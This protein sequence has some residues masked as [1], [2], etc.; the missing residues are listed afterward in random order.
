MPTDF[1]KTLGTPN[2]SQG[3]FDPR[4]SG[5]NY[6]SV[7][8][9]VVS[10]IDALKPPKDGEAQLGQYAAAASD[11]VLNTAGYT[12]ERERLLQALATVPANDKEALTKYYSQLS[13]LRRGDMAPLTA[14]AR[15]KKLT[16]DYIILHPGLTTKILAIQQGAFGD[17]ADVAGVS[18]Q[19]SA[20]DADLAAIEDL[21]KT[22]GTKGI[23]VDEEREFRHAQLQDE[24]SKL[25]FSAK[26]RAGQVNEASISQAY[27]TQTE[28]FYKDMLPKFNAQLK[29][30]SFKGSDILAG[31]VTA[32][33]DL[34]RNTNLM[35]QKVAIDNKM[36]LTREFQDG[37]VKNGSATLDSLIELAKATDN[38][39]A[40]A[41]LSANLR[42]LAEN[43]D[44]QTLHSK[45]GTYTIM[46]TGTDGMIKGAQYISDV[47]DKIAKGLRPS[48]NAQAKT[49]PQLAMALQF[50]D[51][52]DYQKSIAESIDTTSKGMPFAPSGNETV[53][54]VKLQANLD[55]ALAPT[56]PAKERSAALSVLAGQPHSFEAWEARGDLIEATRGSPEVLDALRRAS[57]KQLEEVATQTRVVRDE[58]GAIQ[59][60]ALN[61]NQPFTIS[62]VLDLNQY[63]KT[64][65]QPTGGI[66]GDAI[67]YSSSSAQELVARM[68][69]QYRVFSNIMP[70]AEAQKW[71]ATVLDELKGS[72]QVLPSQS[73]TFVEGSKKTTATD[74]GMIV[75]GNIDLHNRPVVKNADG[76]IST[77]RSISIGT[78][79]GEVLIPTISDDGKALS[80]QAAIALYRKT[81]R[82]LGIFATPAAADAYAEKLHNDQAKEYDTSDPTLVG[83]SADEIDWAMRPAK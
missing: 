41:E 66:Y 78:D 48:L 76:T 79:Q 1:N 63:G 70:R 60:D 75:P 31:L 8:D 38:P 22:A 15:L 24:V 17:I 42:T 51:G 54:K 81:G 25:D 61:P 30:P 45:F 12:T 6:N 11:I 9:S 33:S 53:D 56:T 26:Q 28:L 46:L 13:S 32:R 2:P 14:S 80:N 47:S 49:N 77:V 37:L 3:N 21:V 50:I 68:N 73:K 55:F 4:S 74:T 62:R 40:R 23:S 27:L 35:L 83:L 67:R 16:K 34:V 36:I 59:F 52:P 18:P 39:K 5:I 19:E 65:G 71:A 58:I 10:V 7:G 82:H 44:Y 64:Q 72:H 29:D 20:K 43:A 69:Q 57:P